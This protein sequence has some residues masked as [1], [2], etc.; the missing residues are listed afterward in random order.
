MVAVD[1]NCS[2]IPPQPDLTRCIVW[3]WTTDRLAVP[4]LIQTP[5]SPVDA[6]IFTEAGNTRGLR[7][8]VWQEPGKRRI[9]RFSQP[10]R[11]IQGRFNPIQ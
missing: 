4:F 6:A 8:I 5:Q 9:G 7:H 3:A 1:I 2:V 11:M 10:A